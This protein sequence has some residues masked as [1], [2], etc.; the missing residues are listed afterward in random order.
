MAGKEHPENILANLLKH[1]ICSLGTIAELGIEPIN[2]TRAGKGGGADEECHGA[3][4]QGRRKGASYPLEKV[5]PWGGTGFRSYLG[6]YRG[7]VNI[8]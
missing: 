4:V 7:V 8:L 5:C 2:R 6:A 3:G 1:N